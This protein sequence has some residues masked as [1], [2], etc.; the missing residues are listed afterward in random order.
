V[1]IHRR[2]VP[3]GVA[4]E[5]IEGYWW[6]PQ[7]EKA[8][9]VPGVLT[10]DPT[11]KL[12]LSLIGALT[13]GR[14]DHRDLGIIWGES[15]KSE[16]LTLTGAW[17]ES[18]RTW[19]F[20]PA[21]HKHVIRADRLLKDIHLENEDAE[22]FTSARVRIENL[23]AWAALTKYKRQSDCENPTAEVLA[24][25]P[26]EFDDG[27]FQHR[28]RHIVH[29]QFRFEMTRGRVDIECPTSVVLEIGA[30]KPTKLSGFDSVVVSWVDLLS[31]VTG[32]A[33]SPTSIRLV[34]QLPKIVRRPVR[35][36]LDDGRTSMRGEDHEVEHVIE[37]RARWSTTPTAPSDSEVNPL[38][39]ALGRGNRSIEEW[40][41]SWMAFRGRVK[42]GLDMLLS[43]TYGSN[44]FLQSDLL[45][46]AL[47]AETMHR[48]LFPDCLAMQPRDFEK[49]IDTA[50]RGLEEEDAE[51]I[52]RSFRNEP[53]YGDRLRDLADIPHREA[54]RLAV[55][56]ITAWSKG[57][58]AARNG[59]AHGLRK[60]NSD[61]QHMYDLT[62]QT[63]LLLELIVMAEIGVSETI[64]EQH[65]TEHQ[66]R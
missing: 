32:E 27:G 60:T 33:C 29:R 18:S 8:P 62:R 26:V 40:Y 52:R 24:H 36:Q 25:D 65:A 37:M 7:L 6:S 13:A 23:D 35:V 21:P 64:Q 39:F 17:V 63:R 61:V 19:G 51:R 34:H 58:S 11:G 59:L 38:T 16:L 10:I 48:G 4:D 30:D 50:T 12:T 42:R 9:K 1:W 31:F 56:D 53:S 14:P 55:P 49:I 15:L 3:F 20:S 28:L 66:I 54:V 22:V 45:V 41:R 2:A 43:L 44:A 57:L 47:G 46:V 5:L